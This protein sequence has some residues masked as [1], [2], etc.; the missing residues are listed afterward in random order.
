MRYIGKFLWNVILLIDL[1]LNTLLLGDPSETVSSR[2]GRAL[3]SGKPILFAL[4]L[5]WIVDFIFYRFFGDENHSLK[6]IET[7]E[8]FKH[9]IWNFIKVIK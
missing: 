4:I 7:D 9:E 1:L 6:N 3:K 8:N 2:L 5:A